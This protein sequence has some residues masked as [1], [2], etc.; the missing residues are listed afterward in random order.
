MMNLEA[1]K[2]ETKDAK[3]KYSHFSFYETYKNI[4]D[5]KR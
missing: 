2:E 3:A 1:W 4:K 5:E